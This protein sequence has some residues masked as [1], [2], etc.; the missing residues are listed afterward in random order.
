MEVVRMLDTAYER[1]QE[2]MSR[3]LNPNACMTT[4]FESGKVAG[5]NYALS[6]IDYAERHFD[7]AAIEEEIYKELCRLNHLHD[8]PVC[9]C[10]SYVALCLTTAIFGAAPPVDE[11]EEETNADT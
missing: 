11:L 9:D 10:P 1:I 7:R 3:L 4:S 5:L 6:A 8:E 2:E